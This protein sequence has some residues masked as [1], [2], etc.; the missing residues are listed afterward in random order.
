AVNK[1]AKSVIITHN[2]PSGNS[3]PSKSDMEL[4]EKI[5]ETLNLI[6]IRL[7]DHIIVTRE[8]YF[9]FLE[10]GLLEI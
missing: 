3:N 9:S 10:E 8:S 6:D 7:I 5:R 1:K 2:H 4:T